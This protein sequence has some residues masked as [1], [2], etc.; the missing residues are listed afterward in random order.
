M[1]VIFT[2]L[3]LCISSLKPLK[4]FTYYEPLHIAQ[5]NRAEQPI[6]SSGLC[7]AHRHVHPL[8]MYTLIFIY[9]KDIYMH[10]YIHINVSFSS[11]TGILVYFI[12]IIDQV[13]HSFLFFS[14]S[15]PGQG[16]LNFGDSAVL[17]FIYMIS[18]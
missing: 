3:G 18:S 8:Y 13:R 12:F 16:F 9:H 4:H 17:G 10:T 7:T 11:R 6:V 5:G 2:S 15:L 14:F 1:K